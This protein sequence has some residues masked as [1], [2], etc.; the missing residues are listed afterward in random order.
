MT[1]VKTSKQYHLG[2]EA[3]ISHFRVVAADPE[4]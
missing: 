2:L 3:S 4:G 1:M